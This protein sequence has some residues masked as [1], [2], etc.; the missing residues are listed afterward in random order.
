M[1]AC[2]LDSHKK[3]PSKKHEHI[4]Q[5]FRRVDPKKYMEGGQQLWDNIKKNKGLVEKGLVQMFEQ[6]CQENTGDIV[7]GPYPPGEMLGY[8]IRDIHQQPSPSVAT[9]SVARSSFPPPTPGVTGEP[10]GGVTP[11]SMDPLLH[12]HTG[13][14][15]T[16]DDPEKVQVCVGSIASMVQYVIHVVSLWFRV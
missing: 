2:L 6:A 5:I 4:L 8:L 10:G 7:S 15:E 1:E 14:G 11:T 3:E 9:T 12:P 13:S 16:Q